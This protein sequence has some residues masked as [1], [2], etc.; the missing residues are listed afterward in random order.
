MTGIADKTAGAQ[1]ESE[2]ELRTLPLP[3]LIRRWSRLVWAISVRPMYRRMLEHDLTLAE[4]VVLKQLQRGGLT[5]AAAADCLHLS[6]S[7]ASRA[8]DRLVRDG[9]IRREE[10]PDDRRQKL[11]TMTPAGR[12]LLGDMDVVFADRQRQ[13]IAALDDEEQEQ[14]RALIARM[15]AASGAA[16]EELGCPGG[17]PWGQ[18]ARAMARDS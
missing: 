6:P 18:V 7:A 10:N 8:V 11:I 17:P 14:F 12:E 4:L 15:L 1:V 16:S 5:V 2:E 3:E 13:I 9:L